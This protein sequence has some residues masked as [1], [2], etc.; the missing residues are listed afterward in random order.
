MISDNDIVKLILGFK[1]KHLRLKKG[2]SYQALSAQTGLSVSYLNDIEKGKKYPKP[3]KI[4]ALASAFEIDYDD[5]IS[6]KADKKLLP[7]IELL[8][9]GFFKYFPSE[10]FGFNIEKIIDVFSN[11]P[12]RISAFI[13]TI[14][15]MVRSY[16]IEKEHFYRVAL[17]SYQDMHDNY[18]EDIEES[19]REFIEENNLSTPSNSYT[20]KEALKSLFHITINDERLAKDPFLKQVRSYYSK[21]SKTLYLNSNLSEEQIRFMIAKELG[22]QKMVLN[23]RSFETNLNKEASFEKLLNNFKASYFASALLLPSHE[24]VKDIQSFALATKWSPEL[25]GNLL[26]KYHVTPETLLQRLTNV[27]P[28][29]FGVD[30]LFFIRLDARGGMIDYQITKELH[31]SGLHNPY[32]NQLSEHLCHRWVSISSIKNLQG[33]DKSFLVDA[34]ISEY[35][36]TDKAYFVISIAQQ[37][38]FDNKNGSSVSIGLSMNE[39]LKGAFNFIKDSDLKKKVVHTTCETCAISDCEHRVAPPVYLEKRE[40]E[41][42]MEMELKKL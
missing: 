5:L 4:N 9:S 14:L 13:S 6:T 41:K 29:Y 28:K 25:I 26:T 1:I 20:L 34:Q 18:F 16:Q 36:Q 30:N 31:L 40:M 39:K 3:D 21:E 2:I 37:S 19:A 32:Q 23:E 35:W 10:E 7:V 33:N 17:R 22:Y 38:R 27:L 42:A 11:A 15:K 12:D 24:F 8:N